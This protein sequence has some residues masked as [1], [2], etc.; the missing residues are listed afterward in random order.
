MSPDKFEILER[1]NRYILSIDSHDDAEFA[2]NFHD[3]G[4]YV[5][6]FGSASGRE[7]ILA[8][9]HQWHAGGITAGKRHMIGAWRIDLDNGVQV[10]LGRRQVDERLDSLQAAQEQAEQFAAEI[11]SPLAQMPLKP[12]SSA[13]LA[14]RPLWASMR[15]STSLESSMFL[16]C[17][18]LR[19]IGRPRVSWLR[20]SGS[21]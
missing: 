2:D 16:S 6:P 4:V 21:N 19:V 12:A 10:R 14:L 8:T 5:S 11:E 3:D 1:L 7:Q 17:V 20:N 18:V 13:T 15:N 9:I